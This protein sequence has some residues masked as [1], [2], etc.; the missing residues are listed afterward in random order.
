M[1]I[2]KI[3]AVRNTLTV[4][5]RFDK[6][7]KDAILSLTFKEAQEMVKGMVSDLN[8]LITEA[9]ANNRNG[10]AKCETTENYKVLKDRF[11]SAVDE[12]NAYLPKYRKSVEKYESILK[13]I[14]NEIMASVSVKERD[15]EMNEFGC[16]M[17]D[18]S[19]ETYRAMGAHDE[20]MERLD[21][22]TKMGME[23]A[24]SKMDELNRDVE[25]S[26]HEFEDY[27]HSFQNTVK[28]YSKIIPTQKALVTKVVKFV[29][30][31]ASKLAA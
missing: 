25:K 2:K 4:N 17:I 27:C 9:N 18:V 28:N 6:K 16:Q 13:S 1:N 5:S 29:K 8:A 26:R 19:N 22:E 12:Y 24:K 14:Q 11:E 31:N 7:S 21:D 20:A 15:T 23:K 3:E 30:E 10:F